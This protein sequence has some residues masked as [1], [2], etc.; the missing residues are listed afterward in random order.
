MDGIEPSIVV[1]DVTNSEVSLSELE[2]ENIRHF[3]S[4]GAK[5]TNH[6]DGGDGMTGFNHSDETKAILAAKQLGTK[7]PDQSGDAHWTVREDRGPNTGR[8]FDSAWCSNISKAQSGKRHPNRKGQP[9]VEL[10]S[11]LSFLQ[12]TKA[13]EYFGVSKSTVSRCCRDDMERRG[14]RFAYSVI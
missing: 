3:S 8:E 4:I 13:A 11:G 5:L 7:R 2:R 12:A 9:V 6:T 1:L 10:N 14:L